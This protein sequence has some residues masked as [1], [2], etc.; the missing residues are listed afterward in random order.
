M[1]QRLKTLIILKPFVF[2]LK[3]A[4]AERSYE[5]LLESLDNVFVLAEYLPFF[6]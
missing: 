4:F 5:T 2:D 1:I 6:R 3:L